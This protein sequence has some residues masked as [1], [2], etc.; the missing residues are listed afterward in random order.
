MIQNLNK[1]A[2][3]I[4]LVINENGIFEGT[5]S[6]GDVRRGLLAGLDLDAPITSIIHRGSIVVPPDLNREVVL[7]LMSANFIQQIPIV[8]LDGRLLGL[9]LWEDVAIPP[10]RLNQIVIMA[11]GAGQRMRPHT[12]DCP[13]PMLH[14]AGKP[15]L[16]HIILR[17][18]QEGF[19]KFV[20][21]IHYLGFM[22][23]DYFGDGSAFGVEIQYLREKAPLGTAGALSLLRPQSEL[24]F[25]VT[26]GDVMS[27]IRYSELLDFHVRH[28]SAATMAIKLHEWHNP[29]GVVHTDGVQIIG[30]EEKPIVRTHV[31]AG[32]YVLDPISLELL[33]DNGYCDMPAL[34]KRLQ[35]IG[36]YV[37]AYPMHEPWLDVG[38]PADLE[39]IRLSIS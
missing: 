31:N 19:K 5:I 10:E 38:R 7:K 8:D 20:L 4:S 12:E 16:E 27:D 9:H 24:P 32:V 21:A 29:F 23:E 28:K 34:F 35:E 39:N 22:I 36:K 37:V 33:E 1:S 15:M 18:K 2:L 11:G 26:N 3:K 6:D 17:A 30:F 13:K 14:V 25:I